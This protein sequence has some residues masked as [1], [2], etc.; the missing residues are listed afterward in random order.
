MTDRKTASTITDTELDE[1]YDR[2]ARAET[3]ETQLAQALT[4]L[5]HV[6]R[7]ARRAEHLRD[8]YADLTQDILDAGQHTGDR[9]A[10]WRRRL[11]QISDQ[12]VAGTAAA[13][14]T[15]TTKGP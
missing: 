9:I 2:L 12:T 15:D 4:N 13:E 14:A 6:L 7:R 10:D 11:D 8:Q 1:L 5:D 3:A